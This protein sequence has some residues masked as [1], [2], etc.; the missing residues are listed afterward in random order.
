MW[1]SEGSKGALH[2]DHRS[3]RTTE[4]KTDREALKARIS[5]DSL[6]CKTATVRHSIKG[7]LVGKC[8]REHCGIGPGID[9]KSLTVRDAARVPDACMY[10]W[11][12]R[13]VQASQP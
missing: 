11:P 4:L 8:G 10:E 6:K 13:S 1:V 3:V 12:Y 9:K 5:A 7:K 2:A